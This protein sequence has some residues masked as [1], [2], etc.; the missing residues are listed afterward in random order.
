MRWSNVT[1]C[2]HVKLITVLQ[3]LRVRM[4]CGAVHTCVDALRAL[5][6]VRH[7]GTSSG[8]PSVRHRQCLCECNRLAD[9]DIEMFGKWDVDARVCTMVS[10]RQRCAELLVEIVYVVVKKIANSANQ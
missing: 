1:N 9:V 8:G 3:I 4:G 6:I 5:R 7:T 2:M 10:I